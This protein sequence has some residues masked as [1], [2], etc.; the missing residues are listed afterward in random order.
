MDSILFGV[1][2]ECENNFWRDLKY[3]DNHL[4]CTAAVGFNFPL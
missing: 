4:V 2:F 1:K 3:R